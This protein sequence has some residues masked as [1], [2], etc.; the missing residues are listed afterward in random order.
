MPASAAPDPFG[1][2]SWYNPSRTPPTDP[3]TAPPAPAGRSGPPE[4]FGGRRGGRADTR[5]KTLSV[6][7]LAGG[8]LATAAVGVGAW[9]LLGRLD[10]TSADPLLGPLAWA[11]LATAGLFVGAATIVLGVVALFRSHRALAAVAIVVAL[12]MPVTAGALGLQLGLVGLRAHLA[13]DAGD[14][15]GAALDSLHEAVEHLGPSG[16]PLGNWLDSQF[17]R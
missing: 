12:V 6:T 2:D 9:G 4:G 13:Q 5:R 8:V 11:T 14:A 1:V 10:V 3:D 7:A 16:E 17:G 15:T